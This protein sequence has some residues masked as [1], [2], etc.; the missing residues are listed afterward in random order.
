VHNVDAEAGKIVKSSATGVIL[1]RERGSDMGGG[2][3]K[4]EQESGAG[5]NYQPW[6][7]GAN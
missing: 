4:T 3:N 5:L 6:Q 1:E 2:N 7:G